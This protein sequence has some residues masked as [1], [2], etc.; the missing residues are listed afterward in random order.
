MLVL[1]SNAYL[2]VNP[3]EKNKNERKKRRTNGKGK[4]RN[5]FLQNLQSMIEA[6]E[7]EEDETRDKELPKTP[8]RRAQ[9]QK[10]KRFTK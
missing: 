6:S 3:G 1:Q 8:P 5:V 4:K 7:D 9:K 2:F 10:K